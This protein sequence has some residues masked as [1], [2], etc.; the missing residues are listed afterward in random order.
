MTAASRPRSG[1]TRSD[2]C[3]LS[4]AGVIRLAV[5]RGRAGFVMS[6][7]TTPRPVPLSRLVTTSNGNIRVES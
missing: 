1:L 6:R 7:T 2:S 4:I 3:G 5:L